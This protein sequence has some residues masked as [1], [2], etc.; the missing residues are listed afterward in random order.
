MS[1]QVSHPYVPGAERGIR[2]DDP[3]LAIDWPIT[4]DVIVSDKDARLARPRAGDVRVSAVLRALEERAAAGDPIRVGLVGAGYAGR[5]FAAR[6]IRRTPGMRARGR[7]QPDDR[8]GRARLPGGRRRRRRPG[9][10]PRPSSSAAIAAGRP[11]VTDDPTLLTDAGAI[12][13]IV[14]ATGEVE[15]GA[16]V[17]GPRPSTRGK[18]LVLINAELDSTPGAAAE[19]PRRRGRRRPDR[20]G[21]RPAGRD[22]GPHR[23][24]PPARLPA[25]PGRQ[26][27]EPAGPSP[28]ARDAAGVRRGA[29][30]AAQDDHLVRR[31]HEDRR[32]DGRRRQRDRLRR[33]GAGH[34]GP[35]RGAGRGGARDVRHR[36]AARAP[37]RRLP[38]RRRAELR[39]LRPGLRG[40]SARP[41]AT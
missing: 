8:R 38:H 26:H 18:H 9:R 41:G 23:R 1:Y 14:E 5:G 15:F 27:Q 39:R 16:G 24:G 19:G 20:H 37:D 30:P 22:H 7:R 29:R 35:A 32:R 11:A 31:R 25:D 21:R 33:R 4:E 28:D 13:V 17:G 12:E 2:W 40:G 10:R 36:G 3:A 34:G 6:V